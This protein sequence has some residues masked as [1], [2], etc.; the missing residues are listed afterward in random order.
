MLTSRRSR[1]YL[2]L[3]SV[4]DLLTTAAAFGTGFLV[5]RFLG[6]HDRGL[7]TLVSTVG[8][9]VAF[10]TGFGI[11]ESLLS[12]NESPTRRT[13]LIAACAGVPGAVFM[14][15][16]AT[17]T[18]QPL[19][20]LYSPLPII[21]GIL[22]MALAR[23]CLVQGKAWFWLRLAPAALQLTVTVSLQ[24]LGLL[25]VRAALLALLAGF[26][27][28]VLVDVVIHRTLN[29]RDS[30]HL[31]AREILRRGLD[32]HILNIPRMLNYRGPVLLIGI[33]ATPTQVGLFAVASS[34]ASLVPALTW[35]LTQNLLVITMQDHA[36]SLLLRRRLI[37][38]GYL[39]S[40]LMAAIAITCGKQ[41]LAFIYGPRYGQAW[42]AFAILIACQGPWLHSGLLQTAFRAADLSHL[43]AFIEVGG[44]I[45]IA[46]VTVALVGQLNYTA[47][48]IAL[49]VGYS[50]IV[51]A[52]VATMK[53]MA[54]RFVLASADVVVTL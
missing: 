21:W 38:L 40:F 50:S 41:A 49:A 6:P 51:L 33:L 16:L 34:V 43:A 27:S 39:T 14:V 47:A 1:G 46:S 29:A 15:A 20:L 42:I 4:T 12:H 45:I 37:Q 24:I 3:S 54:S 44:L 30:V 53:R 52:S 13:V 32:Q 22:Q 5:A 23:S 8:A 19:F 17:I 2:I 26:A 10:I 9:V 7:Y 28:T 11:F 25:T 35:S 18:H 48:A 31:P 36:S